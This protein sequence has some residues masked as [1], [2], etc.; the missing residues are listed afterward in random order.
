MRLTAT[1]DF[2]RGT[3]ASNR[4]ISI[5]IGV[6]VFLLSLL[7]CILYNFWTD[8]ISQ[9][10]T[11]DVGSNFP[12]D[13]ANIATALI[14]LIVL[15]LASAALLLIIRTAFTASL[16]NRVHQLG[17]LASVGATPKQLRRMLLYDG[18]RLSLLPIC[19][20]TIL[21][22]GATLLALSPFIELSQNLGV[23]ESGSVAFS[24]SPLVVAAILLLALVTVVLSAAAPARKLSK[25]SPLGTIGGSTEEQPPR[26]RKHSLLAK[27]FGM[28]G[29]L[30][31]QSLRQRRSSLRSATIA[32][33]L[34]FLVFGLFLS[35]MTASRMSVDETFYEKYGTPWDYAIDFP[36]ISEDAFATVASAIESQTETVTPDAS[37]KGKRLYIKIGD[38]G[39]LADIEHI[40]TQMGVQTF[41]TT[42]M[43]AEKQRSEII[44]QGYS[45]LVGCLCGVLALIGIVGIVA[46]AVNSLHQRRREFAR[47]QSI[48]LTPGS[49]YKMLAIE[50][51]AVVGNALAIAL[52]L[53][54][55]ATIALAQLSRNSL[56]SFI[57]ALPMG[58]Y[59][60]Y[61]LVIL[62]VILIAYG[63]GAKR[64]T[65]ASI[66]ES[67]RDD[68]L[69]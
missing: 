32:L 34:S 23:R 6:S 45:M 59:V 26:T 54:V 46:Q 37:D 16:Q 55:L 66:A 35:F 41:E 51:V 28:E 56:P 61:I 47:L 40:L 3:T 52:P 67:L 33:V 21:G 17:L 65:T 5:T 20:S 11:R 13:D 12:I 14:Y 60:L 30:T 58:T 31:S 63:I 18:L 4:A 24:M 53:I 10:N 2:V 57:A 62:L 39:S 8:G 48:G 69:L 25:T 64:I 27:A 49:V 9:A 38:H 50:A 15:L 36:S 22:I 68:S 29:D 42:D 44:W 1:L 43:A 19:G 7:A